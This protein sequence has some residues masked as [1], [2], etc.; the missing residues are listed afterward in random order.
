MADNPS[1]GLVIVSERFFAGDRAHL[2]N[3]FAN[4]DLLEKWW[5]PHDFTNRIEEFDLAPGG[6]W[7]IVMTSSN[8]NDFAN[9]WTF[10]QVVPNERITA[11]H[12][13][14]LHVFELDMHYADADGGTRLTWR[15]SFEDTPENRQLEK[16]LAAAN[17]QNFDRL[18]TM[19]ATC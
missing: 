3:A 11:F 13:E 17:Q 5:G 9:R 1:R 18:E 2:F 7:R 12:H 14:P 6:T 19:L 10:K 16:F 15:M 8:G 4:P